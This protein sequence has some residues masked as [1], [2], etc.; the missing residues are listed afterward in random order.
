M[1]AGAGAT[2]LALNGVPKADAIAFS[3][4]AQALVVVTGA[5]V[6]L[7]VAAWQI[8]LRV[9]LRRVPVQPAPAAAR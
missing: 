6:I 9:R 7:L 8:L 5:A 1:Q 3:V 2:L 4:A